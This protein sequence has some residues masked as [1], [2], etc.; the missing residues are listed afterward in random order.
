MSISALAIMPKPQ[1]L[2][3]DQEDMPFT[4]EGLCP[5]LIMNPHGFPSRMTVLHN[6]L[7]PCTFVSYRIHT[8]P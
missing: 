7:N 2:D 3:S 6:T 8:N 1:P 5:D 4:E